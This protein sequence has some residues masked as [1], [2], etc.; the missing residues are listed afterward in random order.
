M[1]VVSDHCE[2][3][4]N[5]EIYNSSTSPTHTIYRAHDSNCLRSRSTNKIG[6]CQVLYNY[7]ESTSIHGF[8]G[9]DLS[10]VG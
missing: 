10:R 7:L 6:D 9:A 5:R 3:C 8:L 1:I 2:E 4:V